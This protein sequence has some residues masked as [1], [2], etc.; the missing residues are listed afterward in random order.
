MNNSNYSEPSNQHSFT[1]KNR[2]SQSQETSFFNPNLTAVQNCNDR[3]YLLYDEQDYYETDVFSRNN[4]YGDV[5][6]YHYT[7][8]QNFEEDRPEILADKFQ[9]IDIHNNYNNIMNNSFMDRRNEK[10]ISEERNGSKTGSHCT[11]NRLSILLN[12]VLTLS[13][14]LKKGRNHSQ[15]TFLG[16]S[17]GKFDS[18]GNPITFNIPSKL[19]WSIFAVVEL[20]VQLTLAIFLIIRFFQNIGQMKETLS[21]HNQICLYLYIFVITPP[22]LLT[23]C[24]LLLALKNADYHSCCHHVIALSFQA[25]FL[26][27]FSLCQIMELHDERLEH[28][29]VAKLD[30]EKQRKFMESKFLDIN[31]LI[32]GYGETPT[33]EDQFNN[34]VSDSKIIAG[35]SGV[36]SLILG[37]SS[38]ALN[39][40]REIMQVTL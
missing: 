10:S 15:T 30:F 32:V 4:Y 39:I 5:S 9:G 1:S 31:W 34:F 7:I 13:K 3:S 21:W 38:V 22:I 18:L 11:H 25:M 37:F 28:G 29:H 2:N 40:D 33:T 8:N 14:R 16:K 6:D 12:P 27:I 35:V 36:F 26:F 19:F 24:K 17:F 20:I 23:N